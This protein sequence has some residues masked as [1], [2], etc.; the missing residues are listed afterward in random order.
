MLMHDV[1]YVATATVAYLE[2]Y[3]R[4]LEKARAQKNGLAYIHL[5]APCPTGWR[6]P[7]DS[8]IELSRLA[9]QTN[10]FPLWEAENG[11]LRFTYQVENPRPI[12][13]FTKLNG[14]F[15]HLHEEDIQ[16]LQQMVD[17]RFD[18]LNRMASNPVC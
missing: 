1:P 8:G 6:S 11:K 7:I 15:S 16:E 17:Q 2:D 9:V 5:L 12:Q 14:R 13:E 18:Q 3:V 4:K 10:Y